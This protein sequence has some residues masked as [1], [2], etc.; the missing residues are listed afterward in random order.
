[1]QMIVQH[2]DT[3]WYPACLL[4]SIITISTTHPKGYT[5]TNLTSK[6]KKRL[7]KS[8]RNMWRY[9]F[10][11]LMFE[12]RHAVFIFHTFWRQMLGVWTIFLETSDRAEIYRWSGYIILIIRGV[13]LLLNSTVRKRELDTDQFRN[14]NEFYTDAITTLSNDKTCSHERE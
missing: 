13:R 1:M 10:L 4:S 12:K 6:Q 8:I 11:K 3:D 2:D 7:C 14:S 9:G 5:E